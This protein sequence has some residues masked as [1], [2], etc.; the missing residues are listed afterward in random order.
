MTLEEKLD[1]F[2]NAA[3]NDA[4]NQS[5]QILEEYKENL[6]KLQKEHEEETLKK[7]EASLKNESEYLIRDK[8]KKIS[9]ESLL[10]R[11]TITKKTKEHEKAVFE[12]VEKKLNDFMKTPAY[13]ELLMAQITYALDYAKGEAIELYIN[14]T[15]SDKKQALETSLHCSILISNIDFVG[16]I[17]AVIRNRNVLI[18]NSFAAKLS[19][20]R[21]SFTLR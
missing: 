2:Y 4:T 12:R 7:A 3:I 19:E 21:D 15:D 6:E 5:V 1:V 11:R 9:D 14:Q 18:D 10:L 17:R 20:E 13:M 8:N 16:G